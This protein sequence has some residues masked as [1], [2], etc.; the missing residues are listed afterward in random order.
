MRA[1]EVIA[2][3]PM[4]LSA[5]VLGAAALGRLWVVDPVIALVSLAVFPTL[6]LLNRAYTSRV[7]QPAARAQARY[8]ELAAVA[9]ESFD[10]ALAVATLGL[11]DHETARMRRAVS[12][13]A[14]PRVATASAPSKLSWAT[15]ASSP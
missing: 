5:F 2:P 9:H 3:A 4:S 13:S 7:E 1:V 8:G 12:W 11:A 10:G 15:A 6:V 14:R